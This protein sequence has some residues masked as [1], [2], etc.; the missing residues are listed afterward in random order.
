MPGIVAAIGLARIPRGAALRLVQAG[1]FAFVLFNVALFAHVH[2][3]EVLQA[4]QNS[5]R[6]RTPAYPTRQSAPTSQLGSIRPPAEPHAP[7]SSR[8]GLHGSAGV[9]HDEQ[10]SNQFCVKS[11]YPLEP[12]NVQLLAASLPLGRARAFCEAEPACTG[13]SVRTARPRARCRS[14]SSSTHLMP[15]TPGDA[16]KPTFLHDRDSRGPSVQARCVLCEDRIAN[17]Y[18]IWLTATAYLLNTFCFSHTT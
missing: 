13:F 9:A 5:T 7:L 1:T 8:R 11:G 3:D 10:T 2:E 16:C 12:H 14:S 15:C 4:A 6:S 17:T 18:N